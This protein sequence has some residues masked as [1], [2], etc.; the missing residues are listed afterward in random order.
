MPPDDTHHCPRCEL[1]F[2]TARDLRSH[3]AHAHEGVTG[4]RATPSGRL[5]VAVDPTRSAGC[6]V[7]VAAAVAHQTGQ[8]LD[9]VAVATPGSGRRAADDFLRARVQEGRRAEVGTIAWSV[10]E[11][12]K[13]ADQL[14]DHV[15]QDPET[16]LCLGTRARGAV[17]EMILGSVSAAVLRR[18]PVPVLLV[19]PH[20]RPTTNGF[21]RV[22][23]CVDG[24]EPADAVRRAAD[25]LAHQAG[26]RA[27]E[28]R[29]VRPPWAEDDDEALGPAASLGGE[30]AATA[31]LANLDADPA[32]IAVMAT[33]GR[34]GVDRLLFESV[35][36]E[37]VREAQGPVLVLPPSLAVAPQQAASLVTID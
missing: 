21:R 37:V 2:P 8:T 19:G 1:A 28:F 9:L 4:R 6:E 25:H 36:L 17:R 27:E 7:A 16:V 24:S 20:C 35:A 30:A 12:S 32:T 26:L 11:G 29:A 33:E 31:V 15:E 5:V 34:R 3:C 22:V 14:I 13:P 23:A 10:L 18:S